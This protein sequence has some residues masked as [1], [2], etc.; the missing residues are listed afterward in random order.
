MGTNQLADIVM[1]EDEIADFVVEKPHRH[2]GHGWRGRPAPPLTAMWYAVV[3][4][5]I[6]LK[7]KAKSQKA[8]NLIRDAG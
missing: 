7:T 8:V 1:S 3:D 5:E 6:W 2:A 4:G